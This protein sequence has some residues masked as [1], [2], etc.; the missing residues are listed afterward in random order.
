M[1]TAK[2]NG[3][4]YHVDA[5]GFLKDYREWDENFAVATASDLGITEGL[6]KKHWDVIHFIR[7]TLD[8]FGKCPLVYQTCKANG[9]RLRDLKALFPTGYLR[10]ACRLAGLTY[11]EGYLQHYQYLPIGPEPAEK[12]AEK[13]YRVDIR[14]F[15]VDPNEWDEQYAQYKAHEMK[16]TDALTEKQWEVIRF[17]RQNF[18]KTQNV[19]TVYETCEAFSIEIEELEK[20]F[21]DGYHRGAV[22]LAGLRAR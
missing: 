14:G 11:K 18:H 9:L 4:D 5:T 2:V 7:R 10:G 20:L 16:M 8:E 1:C 19:P 6:T 15:L 22:K 21:P 12:A 3:K 17:L 13:S